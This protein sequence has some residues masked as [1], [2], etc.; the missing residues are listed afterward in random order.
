MLTPC[1]RAFR[2]MRLSKSSACRGVAAG[3][4]AMAGVADGG[5]IATVAEGAAGG[6]GGGVWPN[7]LSARVATAKNERAVIFIYPL[8]VRCG[9][10]AVWIQNNHN[11]AAAG[12]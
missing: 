9:P 5:S 8:G 3:V 12:R 2:S 4:A 10:A 7:A 11:R 6:G 1:L